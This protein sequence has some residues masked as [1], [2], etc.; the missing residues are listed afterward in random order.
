M[1]YRKIITIFAFTWMYAALSAQELQLDY[2]AP[3]K[4]LIKEITVTGIK[5]L[6]PPVLISVSGLAVG[7]SIT[8]PGDDITKPIRKLWDQG[9]FSDVR[10]SATKIE[11][12]DIYLNIFLQERARISS[13]NF[14]GVKKGDTEDIKDLLKLRVGGQITESILENS[15]RII[16]KHFREK[17]FLNTNVDV[18]QKNDT[19]VA[20]GIKLTF[21]I[22]KNKKVKIREIKFEGNKAYQESR[23]RRTLK[24]T[25]RRDFN[26]FKSSKFVE[27]DY[28]ADK[29]NLI[30]FYNEHGYRDAQI[31]KDSIYPVNRKR[32][33]I[34]IKLI[35][36]AQY[37]IRKISWLGN[38]KLP[39]ESLS[40]L[41]GMKKGDVYD[42]SLLEKRLFTDETS[43]TTVYM[44][45]GYLFFQIDPVE[46][47]IEK[48]SV[49]LEMRIFEGEQARVNQ[50]TIVGNN[51]TNEHVVRRELWTKPGDLFSKTDITRSVRQ[52]AQLGHFDPEK[53]DVKPFPDPA[54][55]S[56]DLQFTLEEKAND[57]FEISGGW[58][59]NMFVGTVGIR[60][61][62]FSVRR[63]FDKGA[64]RPVP[65]GDSQSLALRASTNGTYYKA[66][67]LSFSEPWLGGKKPTNFSFSLYHT[68]QNNASIAYQT[69][70]EFFKV[71]GGSVGIGTRLKWPDDYFSL[72][73]EVSLQ[74]Y[75]LKNWSSGEFTFSNGNS[76][77]F[78]YKITLGRNSTDQQIYPR[79]GSNFSLSVQLTPPYSAFKKKDFWVLS[80]AERL[81]LT[82]TQIKER[83]EA[84]RYRW[85]EYHKWLGRVQWYMALVQNLVLY[86]NAQFGMLNYYSKNLGY[87]PFES[88]DVGGD[89]MSGYSLY[90]RETIGLRGYQNGSLTPLKSQPL[91]SGSIRTFKNGNIYNK[92]TM[93]LRYPLSLKPQAAI[94]VLTFVEAGNA[95]ASA[96]E[97]NPFNVHRS[98]GMGIRMFLP[99]LGMLGIDWAYGF[100]TVPDYPSAN[101]GQFHFVIGMPF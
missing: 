68:I 39:A 72:F 45:D 60:F 74:N 87:S 2:S 84:N 58:G 38:T 70:N 17:G 65:S 34:K 89:G 30:T 83:E 90:G 76:N 81:G 41:L 78:S 52:L 86:T 18:I 35:E 66:F 88:F 46:N 13:I 20:N 37:H 59:A 54:N 3:T 97:F 24:K 25:H 31:L 77:N 36:G 53:L 26:I 64:W 75:L 57:Q 22:T 16:K 27:S 4:Y 50:I 33:G 55:G 7:D 42:K 98:A 51:K 12:N 67:S 40:T 28:I 6:D 23:L 21:E 9:L 44:D 47:N 19:V 85:I 14:K 91:P 10:I 11:G 95:W 71:T 32:I 5:F 63:I 29:E 96:D 1:M 82:S 101:K 80:T 99:M 48:D 79:V 94:Y 43:I 69:S 61:A 15:V 93:E 49:D 8:V 73:H 100:D 62:N 56:V 92:Y